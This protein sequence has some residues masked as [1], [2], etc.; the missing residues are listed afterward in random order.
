MVKIVDALSRNECRKC[1]LPPLIAIFDSTLRS[2]PSFPPLVLHWASRRK[3][4]LLPWKPCSLSNQRSTDLLGNI[5]Q[6]K[7]FPALPQPGLLLAQ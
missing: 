6:K 1:G 4:A 7:S 5:S 2:L 3:S